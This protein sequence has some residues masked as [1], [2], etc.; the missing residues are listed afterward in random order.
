[1]NSAVCLLARSSPISV[2]VKIK[3]AHIFPNMYWKNTA[4]IFISLSVTTTALLYTPA[5]LHRNICSAHFQHLTE[6]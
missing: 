1:M 6:F 3:Q 2:K 5:M 4:Y